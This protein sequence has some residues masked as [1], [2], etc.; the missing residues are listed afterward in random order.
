MVFS[1][2]RVSDATIGIS[3]N[4]VHID[5]LNSFALG[6]VLVVG[7]SGI[8]GC[9]GSNVGI[10]GSTF[11]LTEKLLPPKRSDLPWEKV[12]TDPS[13]YGKTTISDIVFANFQTAANNVQCN[14]KHVGFSNNPL[15]PD[16]FH[17]HYISAVQYVNVDENAKYYLHDPDPNWRNPTDWYVV[18]KTIIFICLLSGDMDCDGPKH[19]L[20]KDMDGSLTGSTQGSIVANNPLI[21]DPTKCTLVNAWNGFKCAG[22][23]FE[24]LVIESRDSDTFDRRIAPVGLAV[25]GRQVLLNGPMDHLW[26]F[27][28][29]SQKRLSTFWSVVEVNQHYNLSFTG[30]NP[31]RIRLYLL[32]VDNSKSLIITL[33][34]GNPQKVEVYANGEQIPSTNGRLP[35]VDTVQTG[36][37]YYDGQ[38]RTITFLV[39]GNTPIDLYQ[40]DLVQV[41]LHVEM[42]IEEF[43]GD[44]FVSNVAASL[45]INATQIRIVD[46]R[47]GSVIIDFEIIKELPMAPEDE[48]IPKQDITG[49]R[50][51]AGKL[52]ELVQTNSLNVGGQ[53]LEMSIVVPKNYTDRSNDTIDQDPFDFIKIS[54]PLVADP[55]SSSSGTETWGIIAVVLL[56][57]L[58]TAGIIILFV[59]RRKKK[60][61][62][63]ITPLTIGIS[64]PSGFNALDDIDDTKEGTKSPRSV[65]T[66]KY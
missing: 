50:E 25:N 20:I 34:Y 51:I 17:A 10:Y 57:V 33:G 29:T 8:G 22:L 44:Q 23:D 15:S 26:N 12:K 13:V 31:K 65:Y 11:A 32:N 61:T 24:T 7:K 30:T 9:E 40:S 5:N 47:V 14:E 66:H 16:A 64:R 62:A 55:R 42:S 19:V 52:V 53:I 48:G 49:L 21:I 18:T 41:S 60:L 1:K 38:K 39:K 35:T 4:H 27:D 36:T 28:Y 46:V 6:D 56:A 54:P 58:M 59:I 45:G 43:F 63:R 2:V 37:N 3:L